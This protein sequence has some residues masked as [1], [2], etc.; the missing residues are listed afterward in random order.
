EDFLDGVR[1][2]RA[3]ISEPAMICGLI[4]Q[5]VLTVIRRAVDGGIANRQ[6][7]DEGLGRIDTELGSI[8]VVADARQS[9]TTE[10]GFINDA[11]EWQR[12]ESLV[13]Q[14]QR[15]EEMDFMGDEPRGWRLWL[16]ASTGESWRNQVNENRILDQRIADL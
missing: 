6:W 16:K 9:F 2:Y 1:L 5:A 4:R 3:L 7:R 11:E 8:D 15:I 13:T 12:K 14:V 10:R